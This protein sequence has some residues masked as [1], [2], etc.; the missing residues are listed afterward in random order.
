MG[1]GPSP[2]GLPPRLPQ[3]TRGA[4]AQGPFGG[5]AGRR[6][7]A[8]CALE[9]LVADREGRPIAGARLT[10]MSLGGDRV[11]Q[12]VSDTR[13]RFSIEAGTA[14]SYTLVAT[15]P[16]YRAA[17]KV[18]HVGADGGRTELKLFGL[19]S[20]TGKVTSAKDGSPLEAD[21]VLQAGEGA[22]AMR[23]RAG[24]DGAFS[25]PDVLE[26]SYEL[27]ASAKGHGTER[28]PMDIG[29]GTASMTTITLTG[30]GHIYG[31]ICSS[32][33]AWV[34]DVSVTLSLLSGEPVA[35]TR[36]D[37][38]GSYRFGEVTEGTYLLCAGDSQG[39]PVEVRAGQAVAADV[40][41]SGS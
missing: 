1:A 36:T 33:G 8:A 5:G 40:R 16:T 10:L 3:R 31:A 20:L 26:G 24:A 38:A 6:L 28:L 17:T 32:Q 15:A 29:R 2:V 27:V 41:L 13:G 9:G 23:C 11:G 37:D 30:F 39:L 4:A 22:V 7:G 19:G 14:G 21:L 12:G 25:F 35:T 18:V 34:P